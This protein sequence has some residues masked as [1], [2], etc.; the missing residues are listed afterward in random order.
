MVITFAKSALMLKKQQ[1]LLKQVQNQIFTS[2]TC[3][4]ETYKH[5]MQHKGSYR[6]NVCGSP[7]L[8]FALNLHVFEFTFVLAHF[9]SLARP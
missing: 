3:L 6:G 2:V 8:S 7:T 5:G 4:K 1:Y 9:A